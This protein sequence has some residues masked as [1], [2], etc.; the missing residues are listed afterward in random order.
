MKTDKKLIKNRIIGVIV[1]ICLLIAFY[2]LGK[3]L[4]PYITKESV[5]NFVESQKMFA[6]FAMILLQIIQI[7]V[8]PIPGPI[9][10]FVSGYLFG[11]WFGTF[12]SLI[13]SFLGFL[14]VFLIAKKYRDKAL[15]LFF[16][17]ESIDK[18]Y[19]LSQSKSEMVFFL[20]FLLPFF[21][22]DL[23]CYL[24]GMTNIP[25]KHLVIIA[26]VGRFPS[27]LGWSLIGSGAAKGDIKQVVAIFIIGFLV[28]GLAYFYRDKI[29]KI[30]KV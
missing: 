22:D 18:F 9:F 2:F 4:R 27:I 8:A 19:S 21:P 25:I 6:P 7:I 15:H 1:L 26:L 16:K 23:V 5:K 28:G 30:V 13:G 12:I 20:I 3:Y 24:A 11:P 17:Q 29:K 10:G 14:A